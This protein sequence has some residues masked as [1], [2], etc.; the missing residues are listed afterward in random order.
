MNGRPHSR[1]EHLLDALLVPRRALE[2][3]HGLDLLGHIQAV[4]V[5]RDRVLRPAALVESAVLLLRIVPQ[6]LFVADQDDRRSAAVA[7][8]DLRLPVLGDVAQGYRIADGEAQEYDVGV[9]PVQWVQPVV[10]G[11]RVNEGQDDL[12]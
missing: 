11:E 7:V 1:V 10:V 6:V 3:G 8:H 4:L 9:A 12:E 5:S 2:V